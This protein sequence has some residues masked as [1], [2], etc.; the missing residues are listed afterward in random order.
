MNPVTEDEHE[1]TSE[2]TPTYSNSNNNTIN[3]NTNITNILWQVQLCQ[4]WM[5]NILR[6][7]LIA[8]QERLRVCHIIPSST[9][10]AIDELKD[11]DQWAQECVGVNHL[12]LTVLVPDSETANRL[13][14]SGVNN[15]LVYPLSQLAESSD[16][17]IL[18][19]TL[20]ARQST[21]TP[22]HIVWC[23][24]GLDLVLASETHITHCICEIFA[25]IF[26]VFKKTCF[27][28]PS[29][30]PSLSL[31]SLLSAS[32]N[33][34]SYSVLDAQHPLSVSLTKLLCPNIDV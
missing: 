11:V 13:N 25:S 4:A 14:E 33:L 12:E 21:W 23:W 20:R 32:L 7:E 8:P 34:S 3:N 30:L 31:L 5:K 18:L 15:A 22:Y 6:L 24:G 29:L 2:I 28:S 10:Q 27:L 16:P 9:T 26:C 17:D 1:T 19:R